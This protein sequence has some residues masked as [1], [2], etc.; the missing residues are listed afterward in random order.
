LTMTLIAPPAPILA[1]SKASTVS[2]SL[3]LRIA[4]RKYY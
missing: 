3:N 4:A 2:S 1:V